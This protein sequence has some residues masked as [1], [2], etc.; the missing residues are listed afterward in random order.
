MSPIL[1]AG[2]VSGLQFVLLHL[3]LNLCPGR[4]R[5]IPN[6]LSLNSATRSSK[7]HSSSRRRSN[8]RRYS[9]NRNIY[10]IAFFFSTSCF[11]QSSSL[12]QR[13]TCN[14]S[15]QRD[16]RTF[17]SEQVKQKANVNQLISKRNRSF[18]PF[19]H[20]EFFFRLLSLP[21]GYLWQARQESKP[22]NMNP[23]TL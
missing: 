7:K 5:P 3:L 11:F 18:V 9:R 4:P 13:I 10:Q 8:V 22:Y 15:F 14:S 2:K 12:P 23:S 19:F 21:P 1:C 17:S 16:Y 6:G 20:T